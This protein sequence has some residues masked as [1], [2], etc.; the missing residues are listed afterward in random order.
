MLKRSFKQNFL[1][2]ALCPS[3]LPISWLLKA[4][5]AKQ[6]NGGY[7][8]FIEKQIGVR[9]SFGG[10]PTKQ[11]GSCLITLKLSSPIHMPTCRN[12]ASS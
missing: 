6:E 10:H 1:T 5:A 3:S 12:R 8:F 7:F 4:L 2:L 9:D 11:Q